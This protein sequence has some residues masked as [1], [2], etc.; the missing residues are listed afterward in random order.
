MIEY[1]TENQQHELNL[2]VEKEEDEETR[3][4]N[5]GKWAKTLK[6]PVMTKDGIRCSG[7]IA[8]HKKSNTP[9]KS[10]LEKAMKMEKGHLVWTLP[11][12][13][14][15]RVG[16]RSPYSLSITQ[17]EGNTYPTWEISCIWHWNQI[18][19]KVRFKDGNPNNVHIDNIIPIGSGF[20]RLGK[21]I[22]KSEENQKEEYT[23]ENRI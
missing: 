13:A 15:K 4:V 8:V 21:G 12:L 7:A 20:H 1:P 14:G 16:G 10:A 19:E 2:S 23:N 5:K 3:P 9:T 6:D 22:L 11:K 17:F 18:P